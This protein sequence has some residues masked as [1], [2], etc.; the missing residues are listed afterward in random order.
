MI[1]IYKVQT[2]KDLKRYNETAFKD[3]VEGDVRGL[4]LTIVEVRFQDN[5]LL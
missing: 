5:V 3:R 2:S 1:V 4:V